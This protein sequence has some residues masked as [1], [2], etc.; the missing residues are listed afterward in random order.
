MS[1]EDNNKNHC[2]MTG[3]LGIMIQVGLGA[4][5]FSVLIVKRKF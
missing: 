4:L 1:D 2:S 3:F 5:S